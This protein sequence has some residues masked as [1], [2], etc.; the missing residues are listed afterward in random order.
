MYCCSCSVFTVCATCNVISPV[1][2]ILYFHSSTYRSTCAVPNTAVICSSFISCFHGMFFGYCVIIIIIII[3]VTGESKHLLPWSFPSGARLSICQRL[4]CKVCWEVK[5]LA[6]WE[7]GRWEFAVA[8]RRWEFWLNLGFGRH[9]Y[10]ESLITPASAA[11]EAGNEARILGTNW[12][13]ALGR[14]KAVEN[15]DRVGL[16]QDLP[17]EHWLLSR[18]R[19]ALV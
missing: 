8:E 18:R 5:K 6:C 17:D 1:K 16:S 12:A 14:W 11:G 10:D 9:R 3:I 7:L 13:F 2:Y 4:S 15:L 19:L